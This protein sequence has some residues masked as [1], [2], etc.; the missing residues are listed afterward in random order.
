MAPSK[1][2]KNQ[3][4]EWVFS[5][6]HDTGTTTIHPASTFPITVGSAGTPSILVNDKFVAPTHLRFHKDAGGV[7]VENLGGVNTL[8][9]NGVPTQKSWVDVHSDISVGNTTLRFTLQEL[10]KQQEH[11]NQFLFV[12][13]TRANQS[14][15]LPD[16]VLAAPTVWNAKVLEYFQNISLLPTLKEVGSS[17]FKC[18]VDLMPRIKSGRLFVSIDERQFIAV[19]EYAQS[20]AE[21]EVLSSEFAEPMI[22]YRGPVWIEPGGLL[23]RVMF[24]ILRDRRLVGAMVVD[25]AEERQYLS[26]HQLGLVQN[27]LNLSAPLIESLSYSQKFDRLLN[28]MLGIFSNII[29]AKDTYTLGHSERVCR[30]SL[31]IAE[32]MGMDEVTRNNLLVSS[33]LHDLGKLTVHDA[34]LK[35]SGLLSIEE[36]EQMKAHPLA[37]ADMVAHLPMSREFISGIR[38]HHERWDGTGYPDGL[39]GEAIPLFARIVA[40]ADAFDA[41]TSGRSYCGFQ[42]PS[43]AVD[44]LCKSD[45]LFDPEI[46]KMFATAFDR[47]ILTMRTGTVFGL[48]SQEDEMPPDQLKP[49]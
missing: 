18:S 15:M 47:N 42:D 23:G 7:W 17:L 33:L 20:G 30:Y 46:L 13:S 35:K 49:A 43:D 25:V 5:V 48:S 39:V 19:S 29:G 6:L 37:G 4:L 28:G 38:N 16:F 45:D 14:S 1:K 36:Y 34:I 21:A 11:Q 12:E 32:V 2:S 10:S 26:S 22:K 3:R 41:I 8:L 24:P 27:L 44:D 40:I 9:V 31:A